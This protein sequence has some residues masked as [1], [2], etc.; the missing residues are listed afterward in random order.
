MLLLS[1]NAKLKKSYKLG[2][3]TY[4]LQLA[5]SDL[6]GCGN[7]CPSASRGCREA[8]LFTAGMGIFKNVQVARIKRTK[9]FFKDTQSFLFDLRKDIASAVRISKRRNLFPSIRL[10]VLSDIKWENVRSQGLTLFEHFPNV[11]FFDYT[12]DESR[13][14]PNSKALQHENYHLT[15][16]RSESNDAAVQ[17]V[18]NLGGNVAVVFASK[19][20]PSKY[21]GV[22]VVN[23]DETDLRFLDARPCV[24]GLYAKGKARK[25][26]SGFVVKA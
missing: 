26:T 23:G 21:L 3:L 14:S 11:Q 16:S 24:V 22:P 7:V 5:P 8:C 13:M 6:S 18:M 1:T 15:F 20:L 4:G 10:N 17:R 12:K 25:D 9:Q 2:Y 19:V